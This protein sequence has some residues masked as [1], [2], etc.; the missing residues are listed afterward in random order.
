MDKRIRIAT[1]PRMVGSFRTIEQLKDDLCCRVLIG[2]SHFA[3]Q[4][5]EIF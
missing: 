2:N 5:G 4:C 1:S 3:V